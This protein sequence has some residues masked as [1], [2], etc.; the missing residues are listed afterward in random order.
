MKPTSISEQN[1][2]AHSYRQRIR[3]ATFANADEVSNGKGDEWT[4]Q[5]HD[6]HSEMRRHVSRRI[7]SCGLVLRQASVK[8]H[9]TRKQDF[10]FTGMWSKMLLV[11]Q[12]GRIYSQKDYDQV[13][14]SDHVM[15]PRSGQHSCT[16]SGM[17]K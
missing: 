8:N 11:F 13:K 1:C 12:I 2:N 15:F 7:V 16:Q 3:A 4:P 9:G 10:L 14:P 5:Q 17:F 6:H